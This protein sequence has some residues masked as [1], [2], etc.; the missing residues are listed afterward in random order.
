MWQYAIKILLST[1]AANIMKIGYGI[2]VQESDDPYIS[3]AEEALKGAAE[4]GVPGAFLVDAFPI[5]KYV[6]SWF[7]GAGF[8]KKAARVRDA[9]NTMA[10]KPFR[11]VQEQLVPVHFFE[12]HESSFEQ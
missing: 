1:F 7:P 4:A 9:T 11:H 12:V 2:A 6:P 5:L 10:E 3:I 8:Q